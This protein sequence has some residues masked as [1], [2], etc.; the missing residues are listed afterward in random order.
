MHQFEPGK[1]TKLYYS[2]GEVA[3][4]FGVNASLIR[5]WEKEFKIISPKKSNK[6]NR[7]F[8]VKDL[9]ILYK[10]YT[11]VKREGYTLDGAKKALSEIKKTK[12]KSEDPNQVIIRK[13]EAIK[14]KLLTLKK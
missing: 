11:L 9:E 12:D 8:T 10:I 3:A 2:I 5:F 6:G 13:L 7:M 4:M 14:I 1:L